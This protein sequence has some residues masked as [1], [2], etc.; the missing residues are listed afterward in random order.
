VYRKGDGAFWD[1]KR[2]M[3][4]APLPEIGEEC[5]LWQVDADELW[6]AEQLGA[7]RRLF[8]EQP[9]RTAAYYWCH[10]FVAP[11]AI[12]ATR[13]NFA[14][15]PRIEWLRT[16]RY[17]P[18][19]R[20]LAHEPPTLVRPHRWGYSNVAGARPFIQDETEAAGAVFQHVAYGT[21]EQARFKGTYYGFPDAVGRWQALRCA[22][23]AADGPLR[24]AGRFPWVDDDT[25]VDATTRRPVRPIARERE[26][27][28]WTFAT[29]VGASARTSRDSVVVVDGVFFQFG[30]NSGIARVWRSY[31]HEWLKTGFATRIVFLDR[32]GAG[33]RLEG[34][35]TRSVPPWHAEYAAEDSLRLQS[36]CDEEGAS[37]FVST[38]YTSPIETPSLMLVYDFIPERLG[39]DMSDPVWDEK[40]LAIAHAS[41]YAC[42]SENTRRDLFEVG[43]AAREKPAAVVPLGV[44]DRFRPA[45]ADE[46]AGFRMRHGIERPYF[47]LV[48]ERVGF[49]GYKN[50]ELLF[51][52]LQGWSHAGDHELVCVGGAARL[53]PVLRRL[54]R[55]IRVRFVALDDEELRLAYAGAVA[56]V[57]P[58]RYEGFGLPVAEAMACG[59][60][61]IAAGTAS[62]PEVA[63]D[64]AA[65]VDPA[66][67]RSLREALDA[68]REPSRRDAMVAAGLA[69][70]EN[71]TWGDAA[72][73]FGSVIDAAAAP[74]AARDR[75]TRAAHWR[76]RRLDQVRAQSLDL[77][78]RRLL[79]LQR[80]HPAG[81][82]RLKDPVLRYAPPWVVTLLRSARASAAR[83]RVQT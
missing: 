40:R 6:T 23:A 14:A 65:Y 11:D 82:D 4:S 41:S 60:P 43:A 49:G 37:L 58:S 70:A 9:D 76:P 68:V 34:L 2:E 54:S 53:E 21:E 56:L 10:Y 35:P 39:F 83:F 31:L 47:L 20:W 63:G 13:Y 3:V 50:A 78:R 79:M 33:P 15:D 27:G 51:R 73:A 1:G 36:I 26:D 19:D 45:G 66:D 17:R 38:Y 80:R 59:C 71:L 57:F 69:R 18:G 42:I 67:P 44:D 28:S 29:D 75:E 22:V 77:D 62:I 12:V 25:L 81:L 48:G 72:A 24:L 46:V 5:L 30:L 32:G 64:A 16:W 61:V 7:V 8:L 52:A 74:E 55:G